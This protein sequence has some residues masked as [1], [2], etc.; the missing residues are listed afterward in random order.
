M[1]AS[2][3]R[4]LT[5]VVEVARVELRHM[6]EED[7]P[8]RLRKVAKSSARVLPA[9]FAS[10]ILKEIRRNEEFR[11]AVMRR[12]EDERVEDSIG[13]A[14]LNDPDGSQDLV[15]RTDL[16]RE[17]SQRENEAQMDALRIASLEEQL[18]EAK[19]RLKDERDAHAEAIG[20]LGAQDEEKRKSLVRSK[21]AA[22][23]A[24]D[25]VENQLETM[26]QTIR[27]LRAQL[28]DAEERA[29]RAKQ[30]EKRKPS[31]TVEPKADQRPLPPSDPVAFAGWLDT[32]ERI[33]R[34]YRDAHRL[35]SS[36]R[37]FEPFEI[38][39][40]LSPDDRQA[41]TALIAQHPRKVVIDGY[42]VAGLLSSGPLA[43][44]SN[45]A[46]VISKAERLASVSRARVIVV[47]DAEGSKSDDDSRTQFLST[48]G[49]EVRFSTTESADDQI[50]D[51][52]LSD[53]QRSVVVTNDRE[54]RDR[55]VV[56]GCVPVW[57]SA[58]VDWSVH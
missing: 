47:F 13:L 31:S 20:G 56:D 36:T 16:E 26:Q 10:S 9:P 44:A 50:V 24:R 15:A 2:E 21:R 11:N 4:V 39:D 57:S 18:R 14:Y 32:V 38:P 6:D 23:A 3:V 29:G 55:C 5:R 58:F 33:Q 19:R 46:S 41:V 42:N 17:A 27:A 28:A 37:D 48:G 35:G 12:W 40:G 7:L 1:T 34:P 22:D 45:R 53:S 8:S 49:V 43:S 30:R 51:L 52:I 54:L 25:D